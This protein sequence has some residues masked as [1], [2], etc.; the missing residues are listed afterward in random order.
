MRGAKFEISVDNPNR[1][2]PKDYGSIDIAT[3]SIKEV[4][5]WLGYEVAHPTRP[6]VP[7]VSNYITALKNMGK[8]V[9]NKKRR[10][11]AQG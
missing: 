2:V 3:D 8:K 1:L 10:E 7:H 4:A 11:Y 6:D 5:L 9:L